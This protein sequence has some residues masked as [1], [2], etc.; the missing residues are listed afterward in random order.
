MEALPNKCQDAGR[1]SLLR[2]VA[3]FPANVEL[4]R[5]IDKDEDKHHIGI[6]NIELV[7]QVTRDKCPEDFLENWKQEK[8]PENRKRKRDPQESDVADSNRP[9]KRERR[10][11][12]D[13]TAGE[14]SKNKRVRIR[15]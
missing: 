5:L 7:K 10:N 3:S 9:G 1:F 6:L 2:V 11:I 12:L 8:M 13:G 14:S 15:I 4:E